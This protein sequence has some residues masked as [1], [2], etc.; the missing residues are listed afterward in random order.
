MKGSVMKL[1]EETGVVSLIIVAVMVAT[2]S[3]A[4]ERET[5]RGTGR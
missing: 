4:K 1:L 5:G 3:Y 2:P